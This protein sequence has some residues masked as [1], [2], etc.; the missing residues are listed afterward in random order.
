MAAKDKTIEDLENHNTTLTEDN[1]KLTESLH[2]F[3]KAALEKVVTEYNAIR[4]S[5]SETRQKT[6]KPADKCEKAYME[7][8]IESHSLAKADLDEKHGAKPP[9]RS[10]PPSGNGEHE[11]T[12]TAAQRELDK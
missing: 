6:M 3:E 7:V 12:R 8:F 11:D 2:S 9:N 1:K 10:R 4:D 5:F